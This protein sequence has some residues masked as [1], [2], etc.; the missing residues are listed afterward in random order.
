MVCGSPGVVTNTVEVLLENERAERV[1]YNLIC[2]IKSLPLFVEALR[3]LLE[4]RTLSTRALYVYVCVMCIMRRRESS[5]GTDSIVTDSTRQ[6][7][8]S[9]VTT[10]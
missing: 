5:W 10:R 9:P 4:T 3:V 2:I 6:H 7:H 8:R 1:I